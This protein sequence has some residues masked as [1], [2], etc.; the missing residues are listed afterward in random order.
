M[1]GVQGIVHGV[2]GVLHW[3]HLLHC[4]SGVLHGGDRCVLHGVAGVVHE[5]KVCYTGWQVC[6]TGWQVR[7]TGWRLQLVVERLVLPGAGSVVAPL[8]LSGGGVQ[9]SRCGGMRCYFRYPPPLR[10]EVDAVAIATRGQ[11]G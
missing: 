1:E 11:R 6:Y 3:W 10:R 4:I 8:P 5:W 2:A 9:G 7:Y